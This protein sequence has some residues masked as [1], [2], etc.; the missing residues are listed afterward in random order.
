MVGDGADRTARPD[1][2]NRGRNPTFLGTAR[3][4]PEQRQQLAPLMRMIAVE[5]GEG[6]FELVLK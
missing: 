1:A 2:T 5:R 3:I 4:A 6:I